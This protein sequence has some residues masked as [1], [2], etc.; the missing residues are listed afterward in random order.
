MEVVNGDEPWREVRWRAVVPAAASADGSSRRTQPTAPPSRAPCAPAPVS[1]LLLK[2][3]VEESAPSWGPG[4]C[5]PKRCRP[6]PWTPEEDAHVIAGVTQ[7]GEGQWSEVARLVPGKT[8]KQCRERFLNQL[9]TEVRKDPWTPEENQLMLDSVAELGPCWSKIAKRFVGRTD[10]SIKNHYHSERRKH[11]RSVAR[12]ARQSAAA[13][14]RAKCSE[15]APRKRKRAAGPAARLVR[16]SLT[17]TGFGGGSVMATVEPQPQQLVVWPAA[18]VDQR[19]GAGSAAQGWRVQQK[20]PSSRSNWEYISPQGYRFPS[21]ELA[22][23]HAQHPELEPPPRKKN[24]AHPTAPAGDSGTAGTAGTVTVHDEGTSCESR[25]PKV[26]ERLVE[27]QERAV[28][29]PLIT[30]VKRLQRK[31]RKSKSTRC[32]QEATAELF[33]VER[34]AAVRDSSRG[35][36]KEYH[37]YWLGYDEPTWEPEANLRNCTL[38]QEFKESG[39]WVQCD[40]CQK[41]R[42]LS[43]AEAAELTEGDSWTCA[44]NADVRYNRCEVPEDPRAWDGDG[45]GELS[46]EEEVGM[47]EDDE[48]EA[49][50]EVVVLDA[51]QV[52]VEGELI[53]GEEVMMT[54]EDENDEQKASMVVD[55]DA[56]QVAAES[57]PG[58]AIKI[59]LHGVCPSTVASAVARP[60]LHARLRDIIWSMPE[61]QR[62]GEVIRCACGKGYNGEFMLD[63]DHCHCWFHGSCV[64]VREAEDGV[65][66]EWLCDAC[67][68]SNTVS[69][70]PVHRRYRPPHHTHP[71]PHWY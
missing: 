31:G 3:E 43:Q 57:E 67:R 60:G 45:G 70:P 15:A 22:L 8:G 6:P 59:E 4:S 27:Q 7:F 24:K 14:E 20:M 63:C 39:V 65:Y 38:L 51:L 44:C 25:I 16:L 48:Q 13:E 53:E 18:K 10:N 50:V 68:P 17:A 46:E 62:P 49:S 41:W 5:L 21:K 19:L 58:E 71:H 54:E 61:P 52:A 35:A 33:T 55:L 1:Q 2:H 26:D 66:D 32:S 36:T 42:E 28:P 30:K 64:G 23:A 9:N 56:S 69:E 11:E 47:V 34:I 12:E 37:V 40:A 29:E